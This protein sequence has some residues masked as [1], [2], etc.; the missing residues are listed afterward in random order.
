EAP[1][2]SDEAFCSSDEARSLSDEARSLSD[3]ARSLSDEARSF[4]DEARSFMGEA[5][6]FFGDARSLSDEAFCF[7][8]EAESLSVEAESLSVEALSFSGEAQSFSGDVRSLSGDVRSLFGD[9]RSL[10]DEAFCL[11]GEVPS[12]SRSGRSRINS[13]RTTWSS[14]ETACSEG[15]GIRGPLRPSAARPPYYWGQPSTPMPRL[16]LVL[17]FLALPASLASAQDLPLPG[18]GFE[19]ERV[20]DRGID[21]LALAFGPDS[22]LWATAPSGPHRLDLSGGFPGVWDLRGGERSL[23]ALLVLGRGPAGDT[24]VASTGY[25]HRSVGGG[26]TWEG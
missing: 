4:S 16:A 22:T 13:V 23:A 12:L 7:S 24:L 19:W 11:S 15:E 14:L 9:V 17:I 26:Q 21:A 5:F 2:L 8:D 6:C 20:G 3:E 10:S 18:D 1:S 25:I